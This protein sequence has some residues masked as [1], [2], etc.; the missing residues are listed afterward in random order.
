LVIY[1]VILSFTLSLHN[2]LGVHNINNIFN[3]FCKTFLFLKI[4]HQIA[5]AK[6]LCEKSKG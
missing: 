6:H 2:F 5:L 3:N 4:F 1:L